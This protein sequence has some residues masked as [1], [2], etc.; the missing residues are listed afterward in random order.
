MKVRDEARRQERRYDLLSSGSG[1]LEAHWV[2]L[3]QFRNQS[4]EKFFMI[5]VFE[6]KL[7]QFH[8]F[9]SL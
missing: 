6:L 5:V 1:L 2:E 8:F 9:T 7:R 4:L 3:Q